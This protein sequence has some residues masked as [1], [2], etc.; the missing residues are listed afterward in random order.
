MQKSVAQAR[1]SAILGFTGAIGTR[2]GVVARAG[3][4]GARKGP[5]RRS[6]SAEAPEP[7]GRRPRPTSGP[8]DDFSVV[9]PS[10]VPTRV[11]GGDH[12]LLAAFPLAV[13]RPGRAGVLR[14]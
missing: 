14:R 2:E 6:R 9:V 5:D 3:A 10:H 1:A 11:P 12:L 13:S 8:A 4:N 7:R